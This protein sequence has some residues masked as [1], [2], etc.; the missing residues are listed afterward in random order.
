MLELREFVGREISTSRP[1]S[2]TSDVPGAALI[3]I[4]L[5]GPENY[6]IWSRCIR[7]AVL[8]QKQI[9]ICG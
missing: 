2:S 4:K 3:P 5:I 8:S 9:R 1:Q 6:G 7:L